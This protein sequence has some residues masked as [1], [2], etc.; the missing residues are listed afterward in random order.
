M[1]YDAKTGRFVL[2]SSVF[3][4]YDMGEGQPEPGPYQTGSAQTLIEAEG[5]EP[6]AVRFFDEMP[7]VEIVLPRK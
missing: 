6:L 2:V 7:E 1:R 3:A 4:A 5:A